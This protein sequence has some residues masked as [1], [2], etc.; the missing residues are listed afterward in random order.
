MKK[1]SSLAKAAN[2]PMVICAHPNGSATKG[3]KIDYYQISGTSDIANL[4]EV[5]V[6]IIKEPTNDDGAIISDGM[7]A[8]L[9]NR[10]GEKNDDILLAFDKDT[11]SL[12]EMKFDGTYD[13]NEY[14]W[15]KEG[16]QTNAPF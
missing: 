5:V 7:I 2:I 1:C 16:H 14:D 3:K 13:T 12:C 10:Y 9:K 6:Q 15:K 11:H 8:I 4:G